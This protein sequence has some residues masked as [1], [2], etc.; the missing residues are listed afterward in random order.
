MLLGNSV[1]A[2]ETSAVC[3]STTKVSGLFVS[4]L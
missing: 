4:V 3:Y 2:V 1:L